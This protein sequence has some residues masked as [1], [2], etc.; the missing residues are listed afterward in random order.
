MASALH[1]KL[2][3]HQTAQ[4]STE[5]AI[6]QH[7]KDITKNEK[8]LETAKN[9]LK[10]LDDSLRSSSIRRNVLNAEIKKIEEVLKTKRHDHTHATGQRQQHADDIRTTEAA[11]LLQAKKPASAKHSLKPQPFP[12]QT[13]ADFLQS[14]RSLKTD[15][16]MHNYLVNEHGYTAGEGQGIYHD[17]DGKTHKLTKNK[18][19]YQIEEQR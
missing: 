12:L 1:L 8:E 6:N 16:H 14:A 13:P 15:I 19:K 3:E 11:L 7:S 18:G 5:N 10:T 2:S 4:R 17:K 9:Q